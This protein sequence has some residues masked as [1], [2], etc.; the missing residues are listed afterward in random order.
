MTS[1][2][3]LTDAEGWSEDCGQMC[4]PTGQG[5]WLSYQLLPLIMSHETQQ[6]LCVIT[7][8]GWVLILALFD[9]LSPQPLC[10]TNPN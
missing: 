4:D 2:R 9:R 8:I 6:H 5:P 10:V 3:C 7:E 1:E